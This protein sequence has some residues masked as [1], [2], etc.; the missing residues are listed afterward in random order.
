MF[1]LKLASWQ[2][3]LMIERLAQLIL[4]HKN[5]YQQVVGIANGG[6]H[7]SIPLAEKLGLPHASIRISHYKGHIARKVPIIEG[8]LPEGSCLV[9]DD[10]ID[11][12]F[13]MKTLER[14]F[15]HHDTAVLFWQVGSYVP[16]YYVTEKPQEWINF[17]WSDNEN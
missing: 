1:F 9:V 14:H 10:L 6:L 8:K 16:T 11:G 2:V 17:P 3:D 7:V 15:G 13:T 12:G 4:P 5:K